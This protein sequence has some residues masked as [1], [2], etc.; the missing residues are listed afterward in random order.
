VSNRALRSRLG[1][2]LYVRAAVESLPPELLGIADRL[3]VI[4]PWGSLLAAVARPELAVLQGI[5]ALGRPGA[6][7]TV[8]LGVDPVRDRAEA[9]RLGLPMLDHGHL[10][11]SLA[12]GY[13][14][15]GLAVESVRAIGPEGLLHWPSAWAVRLAH[16]VPCS[17][18]E[19][20]ARVQA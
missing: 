16:G 9:I 20:E 4:L 17:L 15:A 5:R 11:G 19:L 13:A 3:T 6:T 12:E 7:L 14:A 18:F 8:V 2:V 10:R 1:N